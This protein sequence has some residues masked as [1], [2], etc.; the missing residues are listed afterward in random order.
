VVK[1]ENIAFNA[2]SLE[3]S[4]NP[5]KK[6]SNVLQ[7]LAWQKL[8]RRLFFC[9]H[10]AESQICSTRKGKRAGKFADSLIRPVIKA[11]CVACLAWGLAVF[12]LLSEKTRL[13]FFQILND[14]RDLFRCLNLLFRT[15]MRGC[16]IFR[17]WLHSYFEF[18][19]SCTDC[20]KFE[21]INSDS[22]TTSKYF[23]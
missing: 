15:K 14:I 8:V 4:V 23:T 2:L 1:P 5:P 17:L 10:V 21:N 6:I 18:K 20:E 19:D 9:E 7:L 11:L 12:R 16:H 13:W 3:L 22:F